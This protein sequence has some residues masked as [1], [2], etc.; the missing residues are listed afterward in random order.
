MHIMKYK[1]LSPIIIVPNPVRV[2]G[3]YRAVLRDLMGRP[4][5]DS[6]WFDNLITNQGLNMIA[7]KNDLYGPGSPWAGAKIGT[8]TTPPT[9][10]DTDLES[11]VDGNSWNAWAYPTGQ[12]GWDQYHPN[13]P[14]GEY[15]MSSMIKARWGAGTGTATLREVGFISRQSTSYYALTTRQLF[16]VPVV[17]G[18]DNILDVY[19]RLYAYNDLSDV[20]GT[21]AAIEGVTYDYLIRPLYID[22]SA[23]PSTRRG[24]TFGYLGENEG[25][26]TLRHFAGDYVMGAD[27]L[28]GSSG[29]AGE[30]NIVYVSNDHTG[31]VEDDFWVNMV[32]SWTVDTTYFDNQLGGIQFYYYPGNTL[33]R[34]AFSSTVD[35]S[36]IFKDN[37]RTARI[38][39]RQSVA[40]RTMP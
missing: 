17:K 28:T 31:Y 4:V 8:G 26:N 11:P 39:F 13:D 7:G 18:P 30:G 19:Y 32:C 23:A 1:D 12:D 15:G 35:G 16:P 14:T 27:F 38:E 9:I 6:D 40:R 24:T 22:D 21:T 10:T 29:T 34:C 25:L 3:Q 2:Q 5:Y 37:E 33:F 20:T 36:G